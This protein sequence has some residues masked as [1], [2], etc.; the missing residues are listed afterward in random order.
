MNLGTFSVFA[1]SGKD[2]LREGVGT[3]ACVGNPRGIDVDQK[4]GNVYVSCSSAICMITPKGIVPNLTFSYKIN[5]WK[6]KTQNTKKKK[7]KETKE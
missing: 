2:Q 1:G 3:S 7:K 4:T 5:V 6:I